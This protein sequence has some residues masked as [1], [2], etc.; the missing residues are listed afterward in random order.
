MLVP[1]GIPMIKVREFAKRSV[2]TI[3]LLSLIVILWCTPDATAQSSQ[4]VFYRGPDG[5]ID[6]IWWDGAFHRDQ[7][8]SAVHAPLAA[9][10]PVTMMVPDQQHVF[11]RATTGMV[12]HIWW[13]GSLHHEEWNSAVGTPVAVGTPATMVAP[14]PN[15][16]DAQH[17]FYRDATGVV[18]H[19]WWDGSFHHD[20][21]TSAAG[22]PV[23]VGD[24]ATMVVSNQEH[25]FYRGN[26]GAIEHIWWDGSFHH[27]QWTSAAGAPVAT[28]KPA[29]MYF[30]PLIH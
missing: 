23:A 1:K 21:W 5:A 13:D 22:A 9:D 6:H 27:D 29:A 16:S 14:T 26:S 30:V 20:Q 15:F 4:H 19:I 3:F 2:L 24:P 7:W 10:H 17:V 28:G 8:T 11:Y 12:E 25:I 18:E